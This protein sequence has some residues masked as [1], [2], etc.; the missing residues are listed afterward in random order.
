MKSGCSNSIQAATTIHCHY[1]HIHSVDHRPHYKSLSYVWGLELCETPVSY[2]GCALQITENLDV[3]LR[4]LRFED[5]ERFLW[6]DALCIDQ[7]MSHIYRSASKS[8]FDWALVIL[9]ATL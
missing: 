9:E 7:L 3:A 8:A 2:N 4:H 1:P 6:I 5:K